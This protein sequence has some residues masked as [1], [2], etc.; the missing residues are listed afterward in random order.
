L[1]GEVGVQSIE[2]EGSI[3][4]FTVVLECSSEILECMRSP[5]TLCVA[6]DLKVCYWNQKSICQGC[7]HPAGLDTELLTD[8]PILV[9]CAND[10]Q[11]QS[12]KLQLDTWG[13]ATETLSARAD[14]WKSLNASLD[15]GTPYR[16]VIVDT[17]L[18]DGPGSELIEQIVRDNRLKDTHIIALVPLAAEWKSAVY[19]ESRVLYISKPVYCSSLFETV[20]AVLLEEHFVT[21]TPPQ[22]SPSIMELPS[23]G[24]SSTSPLRVLIA[25]DN[26]INQIVIVDILHNAGMLT[27]ITSNGQEACDAIK[28][29]PFDVVLMDCQM[30]LMDGYE[31]TAEIRNWEQSLPHAGRVPIIALT[32]NATK[33]DM[34]KC[35]QA[36]MDAYCS[37][38]I[39]PLQIVAM[40]NQ[41]TSER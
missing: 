37:K 7:G 1:G 28:N 8:M 9:V 23:S 14:A 27:K 22:S 31:A 10:F 32:A 36:G 18:E 11:C 20:S 26:R 16:L 19:G 38:P 39:N 34:E 35:I 6:N 17:D 15:Q 33:G 12:L 24:T 21:A 29:E 3:F 30:P 41:W 25:E 40:I 2:G 4:W 5:Q 13:L